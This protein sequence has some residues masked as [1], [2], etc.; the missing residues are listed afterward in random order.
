MQPVQNE[1]DVIKVYYR[2]AAE[3]SSFA[4]AMNDRSSRSH[5]ILSVYVQGNSQK[6]ISYHIIKNH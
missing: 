2:G 6:S 1:E 5:S 4:T 3:R